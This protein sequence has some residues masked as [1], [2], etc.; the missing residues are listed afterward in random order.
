M[1]TINTKWFTSAMAGA[2]AIN[3][4]I[5]GGLIGMLTACLKDGFN[6]LTL[7]SLV[8]AG[9]VATGTKNGHGFIVNQVVLI[10][11][12]TPAGLNGEWRVTSVTANTVMFDTTGISDQT[13]TG[14]ISIKA[15]PCGWLVPFTGTN[16]A[17]FKSGDATSTQL[18]VQID[19]TTAQY[20]TIRG[21]ENFTDISTEVNHY[22][23]QYM[24]R[25]NATDANARPWLIV[26]DSKGVYVGI[27]WTNSGVYDFYH[28]GDFSSV[29]AG[30][31][32]CF[33]LQALLTSAPA[34]IGEQSSVSD[35]NSSLCVA[36]GM[37]ARAFTQIS[38]GVASWQGSAAS[39]GYGAPTQ[40]WNWLLSGQH[41]YGATPNAGPYAAPAVTDNGYHFCPV[42]CVENSAGGYQN[43]RGTARGLLHCLE[44]IPQANGYSILSGVENVAG[45]LVLMA[46]SAGYVRGGVSSYMSAASTLAFTLGDW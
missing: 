37:F 34:T 24:K 12:A 2:P 1:P 38:G 16:L 36:Y 45:G 17:V 29:V 11:G 35:C 21:A 41:G 46:R 6:L 5:G 32:Y 18:P 10:A 27:Q 40:A 4:N 23:T 8:V 30:D 7:D 43:I 20:S 13:A 22:A 9:N 15:A 39:M 14:T 25:S 42:F 31:G 19:D 28:F 44:Y 26:A 3:G 33:R